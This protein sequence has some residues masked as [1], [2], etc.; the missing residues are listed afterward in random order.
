MYS[1]VKPIEVIKSEPKR[2]LEIT[3]IKDSYDLTKKNLH[4]RLGSVGM[5]REM[6]SF[7][8]CQDKLTDESVELAEI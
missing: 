4:S 7:G 1:P 3:F 2:G 8:E 6:Q 5:L